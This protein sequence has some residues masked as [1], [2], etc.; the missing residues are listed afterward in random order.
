MTKAYRAR[1]DGAGRMMADTAQLIAA[2]P[3]LLEAL[4]FALLTIEHRDG[5]KHRMDLFTADERAKL[6]AAI[7]LAVR[8]LSPS[9][10]GITFS[11]PR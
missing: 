11:V 8:P 3:A 4:E 6:R 2:A 10:R 1:G 7:A 5:L 9:E